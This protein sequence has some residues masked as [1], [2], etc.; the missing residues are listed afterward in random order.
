M[1][2]MSKFTATETVQFISPTV[3]QWMQ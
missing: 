2:H 1:N 3:E